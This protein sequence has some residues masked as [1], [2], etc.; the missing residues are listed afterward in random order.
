MKRLLVT[1]IPALALFFAA[2][3]GAADGGQHKRVGGIDVYY[4]IMP[5]AIAGEHPVPHPEKSMHRGV[6]A[7][8][9]SYHLVVALFDADGRRITDAKVRASVGEL[10]MA[11]RRVALEAMPIADAM[12]YGNY[13]TLKGRGPYRI[14]VEVRL[15]GREQ[16]VEAL[17]DYPKR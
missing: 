4:G 5:A 15:P 6:P 8:K 13:V 17:F 12:S 9:D 7:G 1:L 3:A 16:P 10:G 14:A 2:V 11:G